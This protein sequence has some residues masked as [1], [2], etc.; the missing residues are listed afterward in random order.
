MAVWGRGM[1]SRKRLTV[2]QNPLGGSASYEGCLAV[3]FLVALVTHAYAQNITELKSKAEKGDVLAQSA[4]ARPI[5]PAKASL[6]MTPK[7]WRWWQKAA[8]QD[9][10]SAQLN[11][12]LAYNF[13]WG[14]PRNYVAAARWYRCAAERGN[15]GAQSDLGLLYHLG[16]G[17][18]KDEWQ[19]AAEQGVVT[20][21]I[22][23]SR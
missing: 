3:V 9:D 13:G 10:L 11:L 4:L 19:R 5:I 16:L 15:A 7:L 23:P 21:I 6:R 12:G 18:P 17:V 22:S 8:E 14:V 20:A 2:G 1:F